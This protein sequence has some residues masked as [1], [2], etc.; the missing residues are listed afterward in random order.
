[1]I[2]FLSESDEDGRPMVVPTI[3]RVIN[4]MKG[5]ASKQAGISLWQGRFYEHI[6]RNHQDYLDVWS[7]IEN[8]PAKWADDE[9]F[10]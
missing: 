7:Y 4:H 9:Y 2:L 6:I 3:S 5:F 1:M 10:N 8:N